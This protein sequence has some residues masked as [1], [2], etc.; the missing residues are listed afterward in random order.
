MVLRWATLRVR[1]D[2]AVHDGRVKFQTRKVYMESKTSKSKGD[3]KMYKKW[4]QIRL[5]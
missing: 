4:S 5:N 3:Q 2:A 1:N